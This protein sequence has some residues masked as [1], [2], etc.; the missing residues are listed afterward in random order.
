[1]GANEFRDLSRMGLIALCA[2]LGACGRPS[3]KPICTRTFNATIF[4]QPDTGSI[5]PD[6][7]VQTAAT[8]QLTFAAVEEIVC[9]TDPGGPNDQTT[10][11]NIDL[12]ASLRLTYRPR[13]GLATDVSSQLTTMTGAATFVAQRRGTYVA[14]VHAKRA[15]DSVVIEAADPFEWISIGPDGRSSPGQIGRVNDIAFDS[16]SRAIFVASVRGGVYRSDDRGERWYPM[17]DHKVVDSST[18]QQWVERLS[19]GRIAVTGTGRV[20]AATGDPEVPVAP[21]EVNYPKGNL[22]G[23]Y[24]SDDGGVTWQKQTKSGCPAAEFSDPGGK[25][26]EITR[27]VAAAD[28]NI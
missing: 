2:C 13:G 14:T 19:V 16:K 17:S 28:G 4:A 23:L 21:I 7:L 26:S 12:P 11:E 5:S 22:D 9:Q 8:V 20:L 3:N 18:G 15:S 27:I 6:V 10:V 25:T 24:F 1:V